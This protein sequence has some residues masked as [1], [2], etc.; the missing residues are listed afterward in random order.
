MPRRLGAGRLAR[1]RP[2]GGLRRA[3]NRHCPGP[4]SVTL[5]RLRADTALLH[6]ANSEAFDTLR[7]LVRLAPDD[8]DALGNLGALYREAGEPVAALQALHRA[9]ALNAT[10]ARALSNTALTLHDLG[11]FAMAR[12]AA[13]AAIALDPSRADARWN[14]A[15][16][17]LLHGDFTRG[18]AS[19]EQ[20][21]P[22]AAARADHATLH[23]TPL[24]R[25]TTDRRA[26][27]L[28]RSRTWRLPA[29][30][31]LRP[32]CRAA[33]RPLGAVSCWPRRH[34]SV[35]WFAPPCR[36]ASR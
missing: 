32:R 28:A 4:G 27:A 18:W 13:S 23:R 24:E 21:R 12:D 14:L 29:I 10:D 3:A 25:R 8:A 35:H 20:A 36:R 5:W 1:R 6:G 34:H 33:R 9:L 2:S 16:M 15:L 11:Q 7:E 30:R 19:H 22:R 26:A 31:P 17:E